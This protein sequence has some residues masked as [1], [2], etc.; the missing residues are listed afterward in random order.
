[1]A[2]AA[3]LNHGTEVVRDTFPQAAVYDPGGVALAFVGVFDE[4]YQVVEQ[5]GD[6]PNL[7]TTRPMI[8]PRLADLAAGGI[9]PSAG[10]T[11]Q[12]G[13]AIYEVYSVRPDGSGMVRLLLTQVS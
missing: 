2:W 5:G 13:T 4:A 3:A 1:M 11:I 6:G 10:H 7:S 12:I 8:E 9:T